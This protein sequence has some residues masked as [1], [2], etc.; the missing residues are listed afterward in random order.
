MEKISFPVIYQQ[1]KEV[2]TNPAQFWVKTKSENK[3]SAD[4]LAGYYL[5]LVLVASLA[6]F[7]GTWIGSSHFYIGFA[8]LKAIRELVIL[9]LQYL[10]SVFFVNELITTFDGKKNIIAARKLVAYSLSPLLLVSI[11][12]GLFPALYIV[13]I[14]GLYSIYIFWVGAKELLNL[15]ERKL[16]SYILIS[17][18]LGLF[19]LGFLS[20]LLWKVFMMLY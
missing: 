7:L 3:S 18:L 11:V 20:I 16:S 19:V 2:V 17:C 8:V 13:D 1:I 4:L 15:P 5:P 14:L 12:T 6:V 10:I 9:V